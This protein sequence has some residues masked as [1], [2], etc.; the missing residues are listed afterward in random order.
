M[1]SKHART[2]AHTKKVRDVI[3]R[4]LPP[5]AWRHW[6]KPIRIFGLRGRDSNRVPPEYCLE[7]LLLD[8]VCSAYTFTFGWMPKMYVGEM[9]LWMCGSTTMKTRVPVAS[10][11]L[12]GW[13]RCESGWNICGRPVQPFVWSTQSAAFGPLVDSVLISTQKEE[14]RIICVFLPVYFCCNEMKM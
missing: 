12:T 14:W 6:R 11:S 4:T 8:P 7:P 9:E 5:F 2:H 3:M 13:A 1:R 10:V